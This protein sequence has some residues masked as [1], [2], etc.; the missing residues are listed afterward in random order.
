MRDMW[1]K[2]HGKTPTMHQVPT[3]LSSGEGLAIHPFIIRELVTPFRFPSPF[4]RPPS[5]S[6]LLPDPVISLVASAFSI[7]ASPR[8]T[9]D[10]L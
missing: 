5:S 4:P 7:V 6:S 3:P 1:L 10:E 9:P 8:L 2:K